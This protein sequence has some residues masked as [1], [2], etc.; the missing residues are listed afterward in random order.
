MWGA[1]LFFAFAAAQDVVRIGITVFLISRPRPMANL[2][3]YWLGLMA[4]GFC[5]ALATLFLLRD[6]MLPVVRVASSVAGSAIV[7]PIQIVLGVLALSAA[8]MLAV[9]SSVRQSALAP[10]LG[11]NRAADVVEPKTPTVFTRLSWRRRLDGGSLAIAFV[12]GLCTSIQIVE[13][14][15]AMAVI[16]ASRAAA[17]TQVI[18][19]LVFSLVAFAFAEVALVSHLLAPAKTQ[20][21][22][23]QLHDWL[24]AHRRPIF[25]L[26]LAVFGLWMVA[27]GIG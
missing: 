9:P 14:G 26:V 3:V 20:A 7:P 1:V 27:K 16:L 2:F 12:A 13:F 5:G 17:A 22:V 10:M 25:V 11:G 18:A 21:V 8:V 24:R 4:M 23:M 19:A 15:G 6:F